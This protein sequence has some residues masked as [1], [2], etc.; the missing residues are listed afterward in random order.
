MTLPTP[1]LAGRLW[2]VCVRGRG[3]CLVCGWAG[4]VTEPGRGA[5]GEACRWATAADGVCR[6]VCVGG[7]GGG[8][9]L[10]TSLY[11]VLSLALAS[12]H[13][14]GLF[15]MSLLWGEDSEF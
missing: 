9:L 2:S 6:C 3:R 13:G 8:S 1:G 5:R 14:H 11:V 12:E 10:R 4:P 7:G 15:L